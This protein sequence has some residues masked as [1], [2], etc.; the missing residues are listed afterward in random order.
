MLPM[1]SLALLCVPQVP[2]VPQGAKDLSA[3]FIVPEGLSVS[4]WAEA[5]MFFNPTAM[6]TDSRGRI[7]VTEA[8]NYRKWRGRNP[9]LSH[10]EGDRVMI[11]EDSD[12]DGA[13]DKSSVFVQDKE[14]VA[15]L[16]ICV[17][18]DNRVI[19]S[20]SPNAFLYTDTDGDG[21]SD[22]RE[23][24]LTGFGGH[25]HDHGLHS[26]VIGPDGRYYVA[27]GNAGPHIV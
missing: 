27:V 12:G 23:V 22:K 11:L 26:F 6:D 19:V 17:I 4:L 16:G 13:A 15:P 5:P 3:D 25:D 2:Q 21:K 8:V 24:F 14:L 18:D 20:C 9:G 10:P 1:L 7:W